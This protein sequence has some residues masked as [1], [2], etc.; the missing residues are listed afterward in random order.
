MMSF[1]EYL[2]T[3]D[4]AFTRNAF[5]GEEKA[6]PRRWPREAA[7]REAKLEHSDDD[8]DAICLPLFSLSACPPTL[9]ALRLL[10]EPLGNQTPGA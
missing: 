5:L 3:R 9:P 6:R 4:D 8:G 10:H 7:R 1:F 2:S